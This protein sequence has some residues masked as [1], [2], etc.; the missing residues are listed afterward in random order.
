LRPDKKYYL[1]Q[2][3]HYSTNKCDST[4]HFIDLGKLNFLIFGFRLKSIFNTPQLPPK[5]MLNSKVVKIDLKIIIF[6]H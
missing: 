4:K 3:E 6:L 2:T 1:K 5:I